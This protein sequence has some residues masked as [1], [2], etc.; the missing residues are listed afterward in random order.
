MANAKIKLRHCVNLRTNKHSY[1]TVTS[2]DNDFTASTKVLAVQDQDPAH[3]FEWDTHI[4]KQK[5][6]ELRIRLTALPRAVGKGVK[7]APTPDSGDLT[8]TL[9]SP[10]KTVDPATVDYVDENHP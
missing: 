7:A 4:V 2:A 6:G 8:V 3:L 10:P 1:I 5:A 9:S